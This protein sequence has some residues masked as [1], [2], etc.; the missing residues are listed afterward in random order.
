MA[1][2]FSGIA[3]GL[4]AVEGGYTSD[5][6]K[7][8]QIQ[9]AQ[10]QNQQ[11]QIDAMGNIAFGKTLQAFQSQV[12]GA[13]PMPPQMA[14]GGQPQQAPQG[15]PPPQMQG[16]PMAPPPG[17]P[18][19]PMRP[20]VGGQQ[21]GTPQG[22]PQGQPP[23]QQGGQPQVGGQPQQG[24]LD[25]RSIAQK[26]SQAN[27]GAPPAVIA[28]AVTKFLPLMNQQA[29]M[30]WK[31]VQLALM[32]QRQE[33]NQQRADTAQTQ[34]DQRLQ[35]GDKRIGIQQGA[36]TRRTEQGDRRL[37]QGDT[38]I[39]Q[40]AAREKRLAA[41]ASIRQDQGYQRLELQKQN[42]ERQ[43]TQ[44]GDRQKLSEWRAT[45]D[46]QHKRALE[47]IQLKAAMMPDDER[48][49]LLKDQDEAYRTNLEEMRNKTGRT[50]PDANKPAAGG[51]V[52]DRQPAGNS[53]PAAKPRAKNPQTGEEVEWDGN[54]WVPVKPND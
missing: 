27:P 16:Q 33:T 2:G 37:D 45:V 47:I 39:D 28:A 23:Q 6:Q 50:T 48:K 24:Q 51:K 1:G 40:S 46:A 53:N 26:V 44:G 11:A 31:Q 7:Q 54:A 38:R 30:E 34:G 22:Q 41:S 17:Q 49:A 18:S 29:Q 10:M 8:Q 15:G 13:Q 43:I 35:Q 32:G 14:Q 12:P 21:P 52:L 3:S 25:W 19:V 4:G 42:L 20:Q 36:E 9:A 5:Q